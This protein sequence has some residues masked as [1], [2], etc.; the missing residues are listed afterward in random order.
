[1]YTDGFAYDDPGVR[2]ALSYRN[3]PSLSGEL[4]VGMFGSNMRLDGTG[5][6][7][8][9][10]V[11]IQISAILHAFPR[12]PIQPYFLFGGTGNI[13]TYRGYAGDDMGNLYSEFRVGPHV[14][15]GL[16]CLIGDKVSL[17]LDGRSILYTLSAE[18]TLDETYNN[19]V[20]GTMGL[21]FYF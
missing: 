18:Q 5:D 2:F 12:S 17:T 1:M 7:V 10:D 16:E 8:R 14:G 20:T 21:N 4:S 6:D 15:I 19:D 3:A 11:P 13:R 9:S